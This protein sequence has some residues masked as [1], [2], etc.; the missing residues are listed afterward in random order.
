MTRATV[1]LPEASQEA[2]FLAELQRGSTDAR[3]LLAELVPSESLASESSIIRALML[4][5]HRTLKEQA[6]ALQY[7]R[8]IDAGMF[9]DEAQAWARG[10]RRTTARVWSEE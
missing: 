2:V 5:A 6:L 1:N 7:E 4:V 9:D 3:R 10:A 8:A